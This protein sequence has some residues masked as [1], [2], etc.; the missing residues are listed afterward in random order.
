M[1]D[2][3]SDFEPSASDF[4]PSDVGDESDFAP[5]PVKK[6][7][8]KASSS[9]S[10]KKKAAAKKPAVGKKKATPKKK[11][12]KKKGSEASA[13]TAKKA[14]TTA[15]KAKKKK[16]KVKTVSGNTGAYAAPLPPRRRRAGVSR[17][18]SAAARGSS[19]ACP[20]QRSLPAP[21]FLTRTCSPLRSHSQPPAPSSAA[22][23]MI[24]K[25]VTEANRPLNAT[26]VYDN[27]HKQVS[28]PNTK[29]ILE[30]LAKEGRI[31]SKLFGKVNIFFAD[32]GQF[33]HLTPEVVETQSQ[34]LK[35]EIADEKS[36]S[37]ALKLATSQRDKLQRSMTTTQLR[38]ELSELETFCT[39]STERVSA[40][41]TAGR[42][43]EPGQR[44]KLIAKLSGRRKEWRKRKRRCTDLLKDV[45]ENKGTKVAVLAEEIGIDQDDET[46]DMK[47]QREEIDTLLK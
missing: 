41:T 25:Y 14:K 5:S 10:K 29:K 42:S 11:A 13:P 12:A 28:K 34:Q 43:V 38:D 40:L 6:P 33:A 31:A 4:E 37:S 2:G 47:R 3:E 7:K 24:H 32:Q 45:A 15:A 39:E 46:L 9:S 20:F 36:A 17:V 23:S 35:V 44:A 18:P 1:S 26:A 30:K 8:K 27:L 19:A 16:A 21:S 22:E